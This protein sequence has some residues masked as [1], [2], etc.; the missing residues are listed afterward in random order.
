MTDVKPQAPT[1][2][3]RPTFEEVRDV[4]AIDRELVLLAAARLTLRKLGL[5]LSTRHLDE[6]LDERNQLRS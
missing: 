4:D 2:R 3:F 6:L 5:R 1:L